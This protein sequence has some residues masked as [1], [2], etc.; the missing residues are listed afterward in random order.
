MK[1]DKRSLKELFATA[2]LSLFTTD[3]VATA[4]NKENPNSDGLLKE[5]AASLQFHGSMLSDGADAITSIS[6]SYLYPVKIGLACDVFFF[7][8]DPS[9]A[10]SHAI[11]HAEHLSSV[12]NGDTVLMLHVADRLDVD[13]INAKVEASFGRPYRSCAFVMGIRR[14]KLP[15]SKL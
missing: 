14:M 9:L 12:W 15:E 1:I 2:S 13:R 8:D 10:A 6:Y 5:Q 11:L 4:D 7:G 3:G